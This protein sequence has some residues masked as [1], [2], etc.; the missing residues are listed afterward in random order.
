MENNI[1]IVR[2]KDGTD[3]IAYVS[4]KEEYVTLME[5][6]EL[7]IHHVRNNQGALALSAWLPHSL[8]TENI[9]TINVFDILL[10]MIPTDEMIDFY[11]N[12]VKQTKG[13]EVKSMEELNE[14][15]MKQM[16]EVM[17]ELK[18]NKELILH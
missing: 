6:L 8:I 5:P 12:S 10:T 14:E 16:M 7:I 18:S 1:R 3:I 15:E 9:A 11:L 4:I 13:L 2:L 17:N